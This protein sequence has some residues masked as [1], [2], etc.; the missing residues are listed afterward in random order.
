MKGTII[1]IV[2]LS[3]FCVSSHLAMTW[4]WQSFLIIVVVFAGFPV[5]GF[6]L[7]SLKLLNKNNYCKPVHHFNR[8]PLLKRK[9]SHKEFTVSKSLN[10]EASLSQAPMMDTTSVGASHTSD[11]AIFIIGVIPFLWATVEFWRRITLQLPFGTGNDSAFFSIG[12]DNNPSSSRGQ[13]ML[14]KGALIVAYILFGMAASVVGIS[15]LSV[16]L[17]SSSQLP[18]QF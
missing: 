12:E 15:L 5:S 17:S 4:P 9:S 14:G 16:I 6:L 7:S 10:F 2:H 3:V 13:R 11:V 1:I 8:S 18:P